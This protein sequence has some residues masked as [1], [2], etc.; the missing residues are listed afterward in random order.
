MRA[1]V[2]VLRCNRGEMKNECSVIQTHVSM[3]ADVE[4]Q[5]LL[6]SRLQK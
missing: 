1:S 4:Q 6:H 5:R 2:V 3:Q